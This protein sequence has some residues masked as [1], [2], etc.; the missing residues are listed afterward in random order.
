MWRLKCLAFHAFSVLPFGSSLYEWS[1][2][3]LGT[4]FTQLTP[5][6]LAARQ[7][8]VEH[9]QS[10]PGVALEIGAGGELLPPL[11]LSA[12]GAQ[13]IIATDVARLATP[14]RIN[15]II[16]Q[17]RGMVHGDWREITSLSDLWRYRIEYRAPCRIE[18]IDEPVEFI[19]ST[20]TFEHIPTDEIV[21]L[22][23]HCR[24]LCRGTMSHVIDYHDHYPG[25]PRL[26]YLRYSE[27]AWKLYN[28]SWHHQNRLR[29]CDYRR[30]FQEA[31][32]TILHESRELDPP[33]SL[34]PIH[35]SFRHYS[36]EDLLTTRGV[37]VMS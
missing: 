6:R 10:T 4:Y 34:P 23:K 21:P 8:H 13:K 2:K 24:R 20:S 37:F 33:S 22:L 29:H 30:L 36:E 35:E 31:G 17:L 14:E 15:N 28:P 7:L 32:F 11:L 18:S 19:Y 26:N 25:V 3:R 27:R 5:K 12:A 16:R 9:Y 1:Q